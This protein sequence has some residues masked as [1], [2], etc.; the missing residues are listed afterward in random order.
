MVGIDSFC[1]L[2]FSTNRVY[3][4]TLRVTGITNEGVCS[5][6]VCVD[7]TGDV[8]MQAPKFLLLISIFQDRTDIL[9]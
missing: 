2:H 5:T 7:D 4:F 6:K 1:L 8:G 3:P 9:L